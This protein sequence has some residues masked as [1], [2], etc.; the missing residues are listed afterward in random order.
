MQKANWGV[1]T[2]LGWCAV[3]LAVTLLVLTTV[4]IGVWT[5]EWWVCLFA[6]ASG[7]VYVV[8]RTAIW[9]NYTHEDIGNSELFA[10]RA[11]LRYVFGRGLLTIGYARVPGTIRIDE[12]CIQITPDVGRRRIVPLDEVSVIE[13]VRLDETAILFIIRLKKL[14]SGVSVRITA[15]TKELARLKTL[16]FEQLSNDA[17]SDSL[18]EPTKLRV[19]SVRNDYAIVV[20]AAVTAMYILVRYLVGHQ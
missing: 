1:R 20:F 17:T 5:I 19:R 15:N 10:S 11:D 8:N 14:L 6:F 3:G 9:P 13:V 4:M 12:R 7:T 2:A 18:V 16:I